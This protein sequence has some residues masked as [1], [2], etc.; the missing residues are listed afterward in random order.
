M[1]FITKKPKTKQDFEL[2]YDDYFFYI[3]PYAHMGDSHLM[4]NDLELEL[5]DDGTI[6]SVSGLCP[7]LEYEKIDEAPEKYEKYALV[8]LLNITLTPGVGYRLNDFTNWWPIYINKKKGWVCV[9][10]P[11][12]KNK[13]LVE[14]AP[15]CIATLDGEELIALWLHPKTLNLK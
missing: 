9:G 11:D 13:H 1:K 2:F 8:A 12:M 6:M 7:L 5:D 10:N 14:F 3:E 4:I 15:G